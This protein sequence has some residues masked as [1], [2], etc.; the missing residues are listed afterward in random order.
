MTREIKW[1]RCFRIRDDRLDLFLIK[2]GELRSELSHFEAGPIFHIDTKYDVIV[3][4][5]GLT[6]P[7]QEN[8]LADFAEEIK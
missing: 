4:E 5:Y 7:F 6:Y 3:N 8:R 1:Q 2:I